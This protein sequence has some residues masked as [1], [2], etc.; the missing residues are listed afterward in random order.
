VA[1]FESIQTLELRIGTTLDIQT[2]QIAFWN[3]FWVFVGVVAGAAI[4]YRLMNKSLAKQ[5]E[6]W[7]L[8]YYKLKQ[9]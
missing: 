8:P 2:I 1:S 4:Q 5:R 9:R 6:K 3:G 7:H